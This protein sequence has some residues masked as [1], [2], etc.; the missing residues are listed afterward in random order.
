MAEFGPYATLVKAEPDELVK[1]FQPNDI[2]IVA[3]GR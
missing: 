3:A 2:N 1:I